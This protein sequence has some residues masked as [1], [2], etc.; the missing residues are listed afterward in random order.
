MI[1]KKLNNKIMMEIKT[2]QKVKHKINQKMKIKG[3]LLSLM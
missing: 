1:K 2:M 3:K